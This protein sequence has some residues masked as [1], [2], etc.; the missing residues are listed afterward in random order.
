[1]TPDLPGGGRRSRHLAVSEVV[2]TLL[3]VTIVIIG[4]A[5]VGTLII[6]QP[7]P[8]E[9]PA[10]HAIISNQ[11][12]GVYILHR[13]GDPLRAGEFQVLV[14]G[15]DRTSLF[16]N[17]GDEPW[18]VGETL[19]A[20]LP[21]M[22]SH[23]AMVLNQSGA[24]P[25]VLLAKTLEV[26]RKV[27]DPSDVNWFN[28]D[29]TGRCD[30]EYRKS[31]TIPAGKVSGTLTNFPVLIS[32][33]SDPDLAAYAKDDGTSIV[34][35]GEDGTTKLSHEIESFTKATGTLTAWVKLPSL[36]STEETVLWMY[37]GNT[38]A[39][40]QQDVANVWTADYNAAWHLKELGSGAA[41]E[42]K[43]STGNPNSGRGGGGTAAQ[44]PAQAAGKIS[45]AQDFDATNDNIQAGSDASVDDIFAAGGTLSAW[46]YPTGIGENSEG[47]V[48]DKSNSNVNGGG[49]WGFAT[50][51]NNVMTFRKGF[52]TTHG[53]WRT[54]DGSI[55]LNGWNHVAVTYTHGAAND[56]IIYINGVSQAI[57]EFS[58]PAGA[59]QTDA[60]RTMTLGN[61]AS[62]TSRTFDGIIDEVRATKSARSADWIATEYAN[63][64]D[65]SGFISMGSTEE[66]W[67]C[68]AA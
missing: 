24:G 34:F 17:D 63:Q 16:L 6:S 38:G 31:I 35:T 3:L 32:L 53:A 12:M 68:P 11:S 36:S 42:Y 22:P 58:T 13:G 29:S 52:A 39:A 41:G 48:A 44:V 62:G 61:L 40:D 2:G 10:F 7:L 14:D 33:A 28:Y 56:P 59:A 21:A 51:T 23:V 45:Y 8:S 54:P 50:Y 15:I 4:M 47:R 26:P 67:K 9:V 49:G 37:F 46:I 1:M 20:T 55:T 18:S 64:D 66:W 27:W 25:T 19:S 65:P 57:T 5:V 43:D 30:W 60:A